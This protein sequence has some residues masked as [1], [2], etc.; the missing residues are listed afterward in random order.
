MPRKDKTLSAFAV[1][2]KFNSLGESLF[3]TP[4]C[5]PRGIN[6][7]D[8]NVMRSAVLNIL[9]TTKMP[10]KIFENCG[11]KLSIKFHMSLIFGAKLADSA[12]CLW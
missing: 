5:N 9:Q 6:L 10:N 8:N 1:L 2:C 12:S 7:A 11:N 4:S 3:L